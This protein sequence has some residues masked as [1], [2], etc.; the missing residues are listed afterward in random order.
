LRILD[1][2]ASGRRKSL[3]LAFLPEVVGRARRF[4]AAQE[5]AIVDSAGGW[6]F[7]LGKHSIARI[8]RDLANAVA[9]RPEA[10]TVKRQGG[11]QFGIERHAICFPL[12]PASFSPSHV[13]TRAGTLR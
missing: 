3:R 12:D 11:C 1:R 6:R 10:E 5:I 4:A 7:D 9:S 8:V 2:A 13:E